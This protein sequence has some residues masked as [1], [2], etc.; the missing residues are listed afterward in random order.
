[1]QQLFVGLDMGSPTVK[2]FGLRLIWSGFRMQRCRSKVKN[3]L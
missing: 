1:M 2:A 3:R